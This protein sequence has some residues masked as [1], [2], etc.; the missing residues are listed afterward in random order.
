MT[1]ISVRFDK[2]TIKEIDRLISAGLYR[3]RSEAIRKLVTE[4]LKRKQ[5]KLVDDK[6]S[7]LLKRL[8]E[9]R[10][11]GELPIRIITEKTASELVEEGRNRSKYL[12]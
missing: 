2:E 9:K 12:H 4:A 10:K 7:V 1:I 3:S 11:R 6:V 5:V 8:I